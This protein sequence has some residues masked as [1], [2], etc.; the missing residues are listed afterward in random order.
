MFWIHYNRRTDA[1]DQTDAVQMT[2]AVD[3]SAAVNRKDSVLTG[4][5][6]VMLLLITLNISLPA[7]AKFVPKLSDQRFSSELADM[8]SEYDKEVTRQQAARNPYINERLIVKSYDTLD[9]ETYGAVDAIRD[10]DG[11]YILQF[12]SSAAARRAEKRLEQE[13]AVLYVEPDICVFAQESTGT[14]QGLTAADNWGTG[15]TGCDQFAASVQDKTGTIKVAVIDTGILKTHPLFSGRIDTANEHCFVKHE[16][17]TYNPDD[18]TDDHHDDANGSTGHGTGVAGIVAECTPGLNQIQIVPVKSLDNKGQGTLLNIGNGIT[19]IAGRDDGADSYHK[20]ADIIN[21]SF[22]ANSHNEDGSNYLKETVKNAIQAGTVVVISAGNQYEDT[23]SHF[24]A[25]ILD[26]DISGCIVVSGCTK[27]GTPV[28][29]YGKSVDICAPGKGIVTASIDS[30]SLYKTNGGTSFSAP[31]VAAAAAMLRLENKSLTPAQVEK[32]IR[33]R[34]VKSFATTP[35]HFY[36]VG[37]LDMSKGEPENYAQKVFSD[38]ASLPANITIY[39]EYKVVFVQKEY[40]SLTS[41]E[42]NAVTNYSRLTNAENEIKKQKEAANAVMEAIVCLPDPDEL[43]LSDKNKVAAARKR[44]DALNA[45]QKNEVKLFLKNLEAAEKRIQAL[46]K[47]EKEKQAEEKRK[48]ETAAKA[49]AE[50]KARAAA[51]AEAEAAA[52]AEAE[53]KAQ[54]AAQA[55]AERKTAQARLQAS[56]PYAN[57]D[58]LVPLKKNQQTDKLKIMGLTG[59]DCVVS[60]SSSDERRVTVSGNPDGTCLV[61]AGRKT[62]KAVITAT[63]KSG[64]TVTFRIKVQKK[65]VRTRKL[66]ITSKKVSIAAGQSLQLEVEPYPI[67]SVDK[68]KYISKNPGVAAADASGM[69]TARAPGRAVVTVKSGSKKIKLQVTVY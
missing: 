31:C 38:I 67:T 12:A 59:G 36:G 39:D 13:D 33:R 56:K 62:G 34:Y 8:T 35:E 22:V 10:R 42:Q 17:G 64:K 65:K 14:S 1:A 50:R 44:Y 41:E 32:L 63:C 6:L 3:A 60:W 18:V 28:F 51:Q 45:S 49:E 11:H 54:A 27:T 46:E 48:A 5:F 20:K 66:R 61:T 30:G 24:P 21:L 58:Y 7:Y 9:P 53:R 29:N 47:Q 40:D 23:S 26:Q 2:S 69:L 16:D 37:I 15:Y 52:K 19:W 68:V 25:N 57:V 43:K 4:F 55:E